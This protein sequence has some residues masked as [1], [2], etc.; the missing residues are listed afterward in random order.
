[1]PFLTTTP[2]TPAEEPGLSTWEGEFP[3]D[4]DSL[5]EGDRFEPSVSRKRYNRFRDTEHDLS[6]P[7][8]GTEGSIPPPSCGRVGRTPRGRRWSH[9]PRSAGPGDAIQVQHRLDARRSNHS[10]VEPS[11]VVRRRPMHGSQHRS[12]RADRQRGQCN[13]LREDAPIPFHR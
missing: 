7:R 5:L 11:G 13:I 4:M 1:M 8:P 3:R 12:L 2:R 9:H 6:L 10:R